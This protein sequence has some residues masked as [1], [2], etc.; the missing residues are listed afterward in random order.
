LPFQRLVKESTQSYE[1]YKQYRFQI[2][3]LLALQDAAEANLVGL[4]EDINIC[5]IQRVTIMTKDMQLARRIREE[6]I[7]K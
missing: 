6:M 5:A 3:A 2:T 1:Y 4:F 7:R